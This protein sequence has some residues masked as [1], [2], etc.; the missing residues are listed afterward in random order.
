[1]FSELDSILNTIPDFK[2]KTFEIIMK[3]HN[4]EFQIT[5]H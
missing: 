1:M 4:L 2:K 5:F 3:M